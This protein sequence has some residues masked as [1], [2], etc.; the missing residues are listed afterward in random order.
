MTACPISV[1]KSA[2]A[3]EILELLRQNRMDEI[4]VVDDQNAICGMIDV[5][6]LSR[7]RLI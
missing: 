3:V 7:H 6:D 1:R 2:M 5:Q 4:V